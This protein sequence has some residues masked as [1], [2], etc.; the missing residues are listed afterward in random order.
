M[1]TGL[2][3][4]TTLSTSWST[5]QSEQ[6][7]LDEANRQ[8]HAQLLVGRPD[9]YTWEDLTGYLVRAEVELG[10]VSGVG[11]G[12]TGADA[13][14]RSMTFTV[15]NEGM[16]VPAWPEDTSQ[17]E[18]YVVGDESDV[19]G[20][21]KESAALLI[22][23]LFGTKHK[24]ARDGFSP[25]DQTSA[26]NRFKGDFAPI[27]RPMAEVA[28]RAAV[29]PL[30]VQPTAIDWVTLFHGFID[31]TTTSGSDV[32]VQCRDLAKRLMY[33]YIYEAEEFGDDDN[34]VPA[35]TVIQQILNRYIK[36]ATPQ[37]YVPKQP[38]FRCGRFRTQYQS[39]WDAIQ[40]VAAQFGWFLGYRWV[41]AL[42]AFRLVLMEPPRLKD[43]GSADFYLTH[44]KHIYD[45]TDEIGDDQIRNVAV[46]E[47]TEKATG[48]RKTV[49]V[50]NEASIAQWEE[51]AMQFSEG[52]LSLIDTEEEAL[53]LGE[54]AVHD[55]GEIVGS[56]TVVTPLMPTADVFTGVV[57][58]DPRISSTE[59]FMGVVSVRHVLDFDAKVFETEMVGQSRVVGGDKRWRKMQTR[60][61]A[62]PPV[63][64]EDISGG[65][66]TLP[67]PSG[68][69]VTPFIE[70][71]TV[72]IP[73][74]PV[75]SV[76]WAATLVEVSTDPSFPEMSTRR[77]V[78]KASKFEFDGLTGGV[79]HFVRSAYLD[80]SG[81]FSPY[82][83]VLTGV[84]RSVAEGLPGDLFQ[85]KASSDVTPDAGSLDNLWDMDVS[86]G[87]VWS[88]GPVTV[89]FEYPMQWFF[90]MV[91]L[92]T[93]TGR[94]YYVE[95][96]T[97]E[98][99]WTKVT[100]DHTSV[101]NGYTVQRFASNK[102]IVT[103]ALRVTFPGS[104]PVDLREL[105]FWT[106]TLADEILTQ[107]LRLT[108]SMKITNEAGTVE[109]DASGF[110]MTAAD[111]SQITIDA[112]SVEIV[113]ND[114]RTKF[115]GDRWEVYDDN[116]ELRVRIGKL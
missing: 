55:C 59:D 28:L 76:R 109:I 62:K 23:R 52:E 57:I 3:L 105:K 20:D 16:L 78:N 104:S 110:R 58:A 41:P 100:G 43:S 77:A 67:A 94:A 48:E 79:T 71:L 74:P 84:P 72:Q 69:Q 68:G 89:T 93:T 8:I 36:T 61:G 91:R 17:D 85:I 66:V 7:W 70:G 38:P 6:F 90:D 108:G 4:P 34:P 106:I 107:I 114:G 75:H 30:G 96:R 10:D 18:T 1:A 39:V 33:T 19:I 44:V 116:D 49:I 37:L 50:R 24:Y 42:G 54:A 12:G 22:D 113:S 73:T 45:H 88:S 27:L 26:W 40:N 81:S 102:M 115:T 21:E 98:G 95:A 29:T 46:I 103:D 14:V 53:A 101:A 87:A 112:G 97:K 60:P 111:G 31:K 86:T 63:P 35:A 82:S 5:A 15:Q 56:K 2:T 92:Y 80:V 99:T 9:G 83:T 25:R 11:T 51:R 64:P 13:V 32:T 65:G 47:F